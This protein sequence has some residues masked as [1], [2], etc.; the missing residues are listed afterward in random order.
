LS[1][2]WAETA[3]RGSSALIVQ[4]FLKWKD[5]AD[6]ARRAA[7][8]SALA[9][10][11]LDGPLEL[12]ERVAAEA[13]LTLLLDDPSPKVRLTLADVLSTSRKAPIQIIAELARDQIDVASLIIARSPVIGERDLIERARSA[14]EVLQCLIADRAEVPR[15]LA[16]TL[17]RHGTARCVAVLLE[18]RNARICHEVRMLAAERFKGDAHVRGALLDRADLEPE[19]R[20]VLMKS[21]GD[22]LGESGLLRF[23]VGADA[24]APIMRDVEQR[25]LC[26]LLRELDGADHDRLVEA[27]RIGDDLTVVLLLRMVCFGQIDFLASVLAVLA[28]MAPA[29]VTAILADERATQL[30]ALLAKAGLA[31]GVQPVLIHAIGLWRDVAIGRLAAGAQEITRQLIEAVDRDSAERR[32]AANDDILDLLRAIHIDTLRENARAHAEDLA[33]A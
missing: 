2:G 11:Y 8:A 7:A 17:A 6:V 20:Y 26:T 25:G 21:A 13:A 28:D 24:A 18:N 33:A 32:D 27:I 19:L 14:P 16:L 4:H 10:A 9:R 3:S 1:L 23:A 5:S 31:E 12:D 30:R 29:H 15:R 22:A